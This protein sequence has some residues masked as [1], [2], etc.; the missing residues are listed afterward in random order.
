MTCL[1]YELSDDE[2]TTICSNFLILD[3]AIYDTKVLIGQ[4]PVINDTVKNKALAQ[5]IRIDLALNNLR[6]LV[7]ALFELQGKEIR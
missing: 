5:I 6:P 1:I 7:T 4:L 2:I 3:M